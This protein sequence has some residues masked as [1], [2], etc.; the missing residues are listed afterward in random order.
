MPTHPM[1]QQ[2]MMPL[3]MN[4]NPGMTQSHHMMAPG[5]PHI[6]IPP[7]PMHHEHM[8]QSSMYNSESAY[9]HHMQSLGCP[10]PQPTHVPQHLQ[11]LSAQQSIMP[12]TSES[13]VVSNSVSYPEP[14][15]PNIHMEQPIQMPS[16]QQPQEEVAPLLQQQQEQLPQQQIQPPLMPQSP[17]ELEPQPRNESP[18]MERMSESPTTQTDVQ[19]PELETDVKRDS[20]P[21]LKSPIP[22]PNVIQSETIENDNAS[23]GSRQSRSLSPAELNEPQ[24][25]ERDCWSGSEHDPPPPTLTAE[26]SPPISPKDENKTVETSVFNFT[27]DEEPPPPLHSLPERTPRKLK[28]LSRYFKCFKVFINFHFVR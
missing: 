18:I 14:V 26:I 22:S 25:L 24:S 21:D 8:P 28:G 1:A 27:E 6:G 2:D 20:I 15:M 13:Q 11:Q 10:P 7:N 3:H 9:H 4:M 17:V 12:G 23:L 5:M 19:S 16:E